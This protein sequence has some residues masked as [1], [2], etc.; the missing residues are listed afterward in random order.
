M[1]PGTIMRTDKHMSLSLR[2]YSILKVQKL[3]T[4]GQYIN[5]A[6]KMNKWTF[7]VNKEIIYE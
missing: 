6:D 1:H 2:V 4:L 5:S 7:L 3:E